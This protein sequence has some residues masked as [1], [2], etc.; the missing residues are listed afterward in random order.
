MDFRDSISIDDTEC[1][2]DGGKFVN[3]NA[4]DGPFLDVNVLEA[5][6]FQENLKLPNILAALSDKTRAVGAAL[7]RRSSQR[8]K[9]K[10]TTF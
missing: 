7:G 3:V 2:E 8:I 10:L 1:G 4:V 6:V 5:D 9:Q